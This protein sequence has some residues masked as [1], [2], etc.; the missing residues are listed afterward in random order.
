M[1]T[2]G[3]KLAEPTKVDWDKIGG[4]NYQAP[5]PA[6]DP[7]TGKNII[8][9]GQLPPIIAEEQDDEGYRSYLL[10]PIKVTKSGP[11]ADGYVIRFTRVGLRP[12]SNGNNSAALLVKASGVPAKP[13]TTSEYDNA[14]KMVRGK[15]AA[16]SIDWK[17]R[18]SETGEVVRGYA[19]FPDDPAR[20]G[21]KKAILK[22]GDTYT[23][24][25]TKETK[26]VKSDVLFAN[27]VV[28]FFETKK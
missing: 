4:G 27:A 22:Q 28:R 24:P 5:P 25:E 9:F 15:I 26:V 20:P 21:F 18:N 13:Q 14:M 3:L 2:A 1:D 12:W 8:Y 23:D 10:D 17:A 7:T 11:G 6:V 19:N 16:F